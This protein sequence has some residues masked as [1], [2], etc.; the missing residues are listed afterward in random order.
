MA[1]NSIK[2][3]HHLWTRDTIKNVSGD[4]TLDIDG[5]VEFDGC[6]VGFD[7]VTATW[8]TSAVIGSP[9]DGTDVDFR[10]GN[11]AELTLEDDMGVDDLLNLI[12]PAV[13]GNFILVL[14]HDPDG[15]YDIHDNAWTAYASDGSLADSTLAENGTDGEVRWAGGATPTLSANGRD[16][17]VISIYWDADT[18]TALAVASLDFAAV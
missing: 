12:F 18:Q 1:S 15:G 7:K 10:L 4:I 5:H 2:R 9:N 17:D 3:D 16:I 8:S 13:S 14:M 11:K 6:G